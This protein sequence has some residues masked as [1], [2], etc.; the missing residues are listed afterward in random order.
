MSITQ[1]SVKIVKS[2]FQNPL[3][4]GAKH[5]ECIPIIASVLYGG[6]NVGL[7]AQSLFEN[8]TLTK[9]GKR[10][11]LR[12]TEGLAGAACGVL[13]PVGTLAGIWGMSKL[14]QDVEK[15]LI[16]TKLG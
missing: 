5:Y 10:H 14:T 6:V 9:D 7:A 12:A 3:R 16:D 2:L 8:D 13:G 15:H 1:A 11:L 4:K